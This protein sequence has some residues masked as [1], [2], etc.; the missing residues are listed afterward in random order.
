[1]HSLQEREANHSQHRKIS[2]GHVLRFRAQW[3]RTMQEINM[4]DLKVSCKKAGEQS[5]SDA[6]FFLPFSPGEKRRLNA[7]ITK[8]VQAATREKASI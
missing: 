3:T 6:T 1:M 8:Y 5:E 7:N 2:R 4:F